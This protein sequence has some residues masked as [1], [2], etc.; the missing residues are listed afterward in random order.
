MFTAI[1]PCKQ[2]DFPHP[3][4][5]A[6]K[7]IAH[8]S[9]SMRFLSHTFSR[10]G[11]TCHKLSTNTLITPTCQDLSRNYKYPPVSH[12]TSPQQ[13]PSPSHMS[14]ALNEPHPHLTCH[15][16]STNSTRSHYNRQYLL[17]TASVIIIFFFTS[18][19]RSCLPSFT[20]LCLAHLHLVAIV[21]PRDEG[22]EEGV[23]ARN[24]CK[25]WLVGVVGQH[26]PSC[27]N[28]PEFDETSCL[29][30]ELGLSKQAKRKERKNWRKNLKPKIYNKCV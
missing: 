29:V 5:P 9:G 11:Y 26:R 15:E 2:T 13:T 30:L 10:T 16:L 6:T 17:K 25:S 27:F 12:A 24:R 19:L 18:F 3:P 14:Q 21:V 22:I 23:V 20:Y 4:P 28:V 1:I 7:S 8:H